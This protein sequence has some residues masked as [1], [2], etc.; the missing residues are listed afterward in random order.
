[1]SNDINRVVLVGRLCAAPELKSTN[2]GSYLCRFT[3]AS[4]RTIFVKDGENKEEVGFFPC[5]AWGKLAEIISK[6]AQKGRRVGVDGSLR[7]SAWDNAEGKRQSKI[8]IFVENF[9]FLDAKQSDGQSS[10]HE[11]VAD[12]FGGEKT[13]KYTEDFSEPFNDDI[14]F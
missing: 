13:D 7:F 14:A 8:E 6:Y 12:S 9:Q 1:M 10:K 5:V 3:L 11:S 2:G 4:N